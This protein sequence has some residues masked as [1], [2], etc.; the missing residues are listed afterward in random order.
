[1]APLGKIRKCLGGVLGRAVAPIRRIL[2][3]DFPGQRC[4]YT[5]SRWN[6]LER[7]LTVL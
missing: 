4:R 2:E 7:T 6:P 5:Y 1:M 3:F